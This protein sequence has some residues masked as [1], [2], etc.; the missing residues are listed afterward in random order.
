MGIMTQLVRAFLDRRVIF[1]FLLLLLIVL[2]DSFFVRAIFS[3]L[4]TLEHFLF[5]FIISEA[6]G[7]AAAFHYAG[8]SSVKSISIEQLRQSDLLIRLFGF[9]IIGGLLWESL[10]CFLFPLFGVP[11][12]PFFMFPITLRNIDGAIDVTVGILGCLL[13]WYNAKRTSAPFFKKWF[14]SHVVIKSKR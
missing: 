10:E 2:V 1:P 13:A 11:C 3:E 5:G 9:L 8:K 6:V 12:N 4:D 7:Q 14:L